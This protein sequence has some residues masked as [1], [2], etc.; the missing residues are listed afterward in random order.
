MMQQIFLNG[1]VFHQKYLDGNPMKEIPIDTAGG[2]AM[3]QQFLDLGVC[4]HGKRMTIMYLPSKASE[5]GK[6]AVAAFVTAVLG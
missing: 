3:M 5:K 6:T 1:H 2:K 4:L